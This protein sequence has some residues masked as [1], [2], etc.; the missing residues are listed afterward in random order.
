[1]TAALG[2]IRG[3]DYLF[4]H[5]L[6][7]S[8]LFNY[9][10]LPAGGPSALEIDRNRF[11]YLLL[12]TFISSSAWMIFSA[13]AMTESW[14][15]DEIWTAMSETKFGHIWCARVILIFT[16]LLSFKKVKNFGAGPLLLVSF[17]FA[18]PLFSV[19][20]GHA[21]A[22]ADRTLLRVLTD[23]IHSLAV[24]TWT[25]GLWALIFWLKR[26][27]LFSDIKPEVSFRLVK[28]FSHFAI[29]STGLIGL[30]GIAMGLLAGISW[31]EPLATTYGQLMAAKLAL[32]LAVLGIASVNQFTHLGKWAPKDEPKFV[33]GVLR[34]SR[35]ELVL[36]FIVFG[37]A[38][39]LARTAFPIEM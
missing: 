23:F 18:L 25:G 35:L 31:K 16:A 11:Q 37:I 3:L 28:R 7:G 10:I 15:P 13:Y 14:A 27:T 26:R 5:W 36:I 38:G 20:T 17:V 34:E 6:L 9:F 8:V 32:F 29:I 33:L 39:F 21:A 30:T 24:G 1:M 19:L 12:P 2:I 4:S 22:Q